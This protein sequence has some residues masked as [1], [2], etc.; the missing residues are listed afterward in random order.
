MI[1]KKSSLAKRMQVSYESKESG[2]ISRKSVLDW[3][4]VDGEVTFFKPTEGKNRI[5]IIPYVIKTKNHPLVKKGEF[6]VG[7]SDYVMDFFIHKSV[8]PTESSVLCLKSTFGKPCPVCELQAKLCKEGKGDEAKALKPSRRVAYNIEDTKEPGKLKVF[9]TS[10]FLFEK[11]LIDEARDDEENGFVDFA[12]PEEGKEVKFRA[13]KTSQGGYEFLEFKSFG[14]EDRDEKISS[15]L[16]KQAISFDEILTIP[17]YEEVEKILYG[18]EDSDDEEDSEDEPKK[19]PSKKSSKEEDD[20]E[21]EE[22]S[23]D[24]DDEEN[25]DEEEEEEEEKPSKKSSKKSSKDDEEDFEDE[26]KKK[27]PFGHKY[28][29]DTDV[30]DDCDNCDC[31][32][33][34][35]RNK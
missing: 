16:L 1:N 34:C 24:S 13:S 8:G 19:K 18:A 10:H 22:D 26:P 29:V 35:T 25:D 32:A 15:K 23:D 27:C 33:N 12:D 14:F 7:D 5:N 21:E 4:K 6:S 9:E 30:Y 28:G 3:K 11:E 2:N 17:T 20:D 31:W